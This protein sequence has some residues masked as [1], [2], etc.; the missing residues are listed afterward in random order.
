MKASSREKN[1]KLAAIMDE[2]F[3]AQLH[4]YLNLRYDHLIDKLINGS[5][6]LNKEEINIICLDLCQFPNTII[7]YYSKCDRSHSVLTKK[8]IIAKKVLASPDIK[9]ISNLFS[10]K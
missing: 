1:T 9:D 5:F 3:F 6:N 2:D 4:L 10:Q 7:W 8:K